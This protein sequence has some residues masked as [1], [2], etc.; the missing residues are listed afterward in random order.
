MGFVISHIEPSVTTA[1][2]LVTWS[3]ISK[4]SQ[5]G[6]ENNFEG[7]FFSFMLSVWYQNKVVQH[8]TL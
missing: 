7:Y 2:V 4:K 6:K 3:F 8:R 1:R 5:Y